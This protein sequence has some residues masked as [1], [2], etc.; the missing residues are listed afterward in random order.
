VSFLRKADAAFPRQPHRVTNW[1]EYDTEVIAASYTRARGRE[2]GCDR[3]RRRRGPSSRREIQASP[4]CFDGGKPKVATRIFVGRGCFGLKVYF[5]SLRLP[6]RALAQPLRN[7]LENRPITFWVRHSRRMRLAS[8]H[9]RE[10]CRQCRA[11]WPAAAM[12]LT[13][14]NLFFPKSFSELDGTMS[15]AASFLNSGYG[16]SGEALH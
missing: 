11:P 7:S 2:K 14:A 5:P 13:G 4:P 15:I 12:V 16:R 8:S 3:I 1:R 6:W 10:L 9:S